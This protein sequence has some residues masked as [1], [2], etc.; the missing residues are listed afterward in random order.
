MSTPE[1]KTDHDPPTQDHKATTPS[2]IEMARTYVEAGEMITPSIGYMLLE[3]I[4]WLED[5]RERLAEQLD[6]HKDSADIAKFVGK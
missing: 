1:L 3:H 4:A 6:A 5:E 2:V